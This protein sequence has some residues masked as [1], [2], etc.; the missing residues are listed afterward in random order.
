[1]STKVLPEMFGMYV[2]ATK[3]NGE[4]PPGKQMESTS[5]SRNQRDHRAEKEP[6]CLVS[7]LVFKGHPPTSTVTHGV[8]IPYS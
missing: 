1:M 8:K 6:T 7:A 3:Q 2:K 5:N 4:D